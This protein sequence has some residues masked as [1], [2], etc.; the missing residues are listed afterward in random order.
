MK[1]HGSFFILFGV[2][3][4]ILEIFHKKSL[5]LYQNIRHELGLSQAKQTTVHPEDKGLWIKKVL[6]WLQGPRDAAVRPDKH[7]KE[8][9]VL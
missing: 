9:P 3:W 4:Y 1:R 8:C 5:I 2:F 7:L 6:T